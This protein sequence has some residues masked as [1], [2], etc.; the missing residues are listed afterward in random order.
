[1]AEADEIARLEKELL[2]ARVEITDLEADL[3]A[4]HGEV[5]TLK[6]EIKEMAERIDKLEDRVFDL[7]DIERELTE[8]V[9]EREDA[10]ADLQSALDDEKAF[11]EAARTLVSALETYLSWLDN[12]PPNMGDAARGEFLTNFRRDLDDAL[13]GMR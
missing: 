10:E 9:E 2:E 3:E 12:P 4:A 5:E 1:M 8:K 11:N 7:E 13:R 6:G